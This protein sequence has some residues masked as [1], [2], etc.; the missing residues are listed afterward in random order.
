MDEIKQKALVEMQL[1]AE[2]VADSTVEPVFSKLLD[3]GVPLDC[4]TSAVLYKLQ[5]LFR[6]DYDTIN[7]ADRAFA[8]CIEGHINESLSGSALFDKVVR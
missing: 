4:L 8:D 6:R 5:L 7:E 2:D 1:A 3:D